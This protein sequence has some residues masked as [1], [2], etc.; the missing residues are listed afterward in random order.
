MK[1]I[2]SITTSIDDKGNLPIKCD[3]QL[4]TYFERFHKIVGEM[5]LN[6]DSLRNT[7]DLLLEIPI[8]PE[9]VDVFKTALTY[10]KKSEV[11]ES[12]KKEA[13]A[14]ILKMFRNCDDVFQCLDDGCSI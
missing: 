7:L 12:R 9:F 6:D 13:V 2:L 8:F 11:Y 3:F 5:P 14:E 10:I 4:N 1:K